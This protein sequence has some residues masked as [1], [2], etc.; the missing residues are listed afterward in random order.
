MKTETPNNMI[1]L[2]AFEP[3]DAKSI[4]RLLEDHKI[5]FEVG[6]DDSLLTRLNRGVE[7]QLGQYPDGSKT[8]LY[9]HKDDSYEAG[10]IVEII[11]P[12]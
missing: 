1:T 5:S 10:K 6:I 3:R 4:I 11:F 8:L 9:V 2:G 7:L 12:K